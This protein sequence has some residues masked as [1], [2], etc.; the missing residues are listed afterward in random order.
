MSVQR[1]GDDDF[2]P[3]ALFAL[4]TGL[5]TKALRAFLDDAQPHTTW[6]VIDI[7]TPAVVFD[8]HGDTIGFVNQRNANLIGLTVGGR[9]QIS[10]NGKA[11]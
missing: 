3:D 5:S 10:S 9:F 11:A 6:F 7:E 8:G 1:C 2:R 4:D